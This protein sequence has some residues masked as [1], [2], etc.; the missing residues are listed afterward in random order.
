MDVSAHQLHCLN[1]KGE[2]PSILRK[3][4][5]RIRLRRSSID[6]EFDATYDDFMKK[7]L[8]EPLV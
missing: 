5:H 1:V 8:L 7:L 4:G 6:K 2:E 3:V